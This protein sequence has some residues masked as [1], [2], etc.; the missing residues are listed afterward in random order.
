M[1]I[2]VWRYLDNEKNFPG[3]HLSADVEGCLYMQE[4]IRDP[5]ERSSILLVPP[6][7]EVLLVPNNQGGTART[8]AFSKLR[9]KTTDRDESGR[10]AIS[11]VE[12]SLTLKLPRGQTPLMLQGIRDIKNGEG[13]YSM[14]GEE[15]A[16]LWFWWQSTKTQK[17]NKA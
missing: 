6:D 12:S 3:Y 1:R 16:S 14:N 5:W 17:A 4:R 15:G 8:K 10:F 11:E 13:D 7:S 9:I 2:C